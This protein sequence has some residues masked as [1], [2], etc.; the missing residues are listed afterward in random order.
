MTR[1]T[2]RQA[3]LMRAIKSAKASGMKVETVEVVTAD[4]TT[5]RVCGPRLSTATNP[6]DEVLSSDDANQ[7]TRP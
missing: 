1:T 4:G 5:I 3:D 2:F 6:W 7:K